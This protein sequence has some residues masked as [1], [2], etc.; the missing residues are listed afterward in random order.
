MQSSRLPPAKLSSLSR[1]LLPFL[2]LLLLL[3][4]LHSSCEPRGGESYALER[5]S[6]KAASSK[7]FLERPPQS[8][9][10]STMLTLLYTLHHSGWWFNCSALSATR[11]IKDHASLKSWKVSFFSMASR[12]LTSCHPRERERV[13]ERER[14][15]GKER[16]REMRRGESELGGEENNKNLF[17]TFPKPRHLFFHVHV[18]F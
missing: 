18:Y 10:L 17:V 8:W 4:L 3:L 1:L 15:V 7:S 11:L 13:K 2:L 12:L 9:V 6:M 5:L 16:K 14:W